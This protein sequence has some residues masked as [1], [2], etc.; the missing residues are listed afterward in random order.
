MPVK[1]N[2][3]FSALDV[4]QVIYYTY[5]TYR[6]TSGYVVLAVYTFFFTSLLIE[7]FVSRLSNTACLLSISSLMD[8]LASAHQMPYCS[9]LVFC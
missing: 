4:S 8:S 1:T 9:M 7:R 6:I 5:W 3:V 2:S